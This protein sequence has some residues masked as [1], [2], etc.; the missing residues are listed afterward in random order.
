MKR[1]SSLIIYILGLLAIAI[2]ASLS[3]GITAYLLRVRHTLELDFVLRPESKPLAPFS[4]I[5]IEQERNS[6]V[7]T[8]CN[9]SGRGVDHRWIV[10]EGGAKEP[11]VSA[12]R[13]MLDSL[14]SYSVRNDTL[15]IR[16]CFEAAPE[17]Q[18]RLKAGSPVVISVPDS[19]LRSIAAAGMSTHTILRNYR[20]DS[21]QIST[22]YG[23][24]F[25]GNALGNLGITTTGTPPVDNREIIRRDRLYNELYED[26]KPLMLS[27]T[28]EAGLGNITA[29]MADG[30]QDISIYCSQPENYDSEKS[31]I[32]GDLRI[33]PINPGISPTVNLTIEDCA[34]RR[35]LPADGVTVNTDL[36][37]SRTIEIT[38]TGSNSASSN[39]Q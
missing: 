7:N 3:F 25:D 9:A 33:V 31:A 26:H 20:A 37:S 4:H 39:D 1:N 23:F 5:V 18:I 6:Y 16:F 29:Q 10:V 8:R 15:R 24:L 19:S 13:N 12:P 32:I 30:H 17:T 34:F 35:I 14:A 38:T 36:R 22:Y 2:V 28:P 27:L 21:L 11:S